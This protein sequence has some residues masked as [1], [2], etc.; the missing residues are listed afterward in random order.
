MLAPSAASARE[1]TTKQ[2]NVIILDTLLEERA[3]YV[4]ERDRFS[5]PAADAGKTNDDLPR[6][7]LAVD[8]EFLQPSVPPRNGG[9]R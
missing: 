9:R 5:A 6:M 3:Q 2:A 1:L 8:G 4:A 7:M